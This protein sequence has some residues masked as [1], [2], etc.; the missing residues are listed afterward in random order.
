MK[1]IKSVLFLIQL[2]A[3]L[4]SQ[5]LCSQT[6]NTPQPDQVPGEN[7]VSYNS[8]NNTY[9]FYLN[10]I[11][12]YSF[13]ASSKNGTLN[14]LRAYN[15]SGTYFLPSNYGGPL[16]FQN[17]QLLYPWDNDAVYTL[18]SNQLSS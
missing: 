6:L 4:F 8:L 1:I 3:I 16:G 2:L 13:N 11:C 5:K 9:N 7:S 10:S 12:L 15:T 18:Q 14:N 17:G